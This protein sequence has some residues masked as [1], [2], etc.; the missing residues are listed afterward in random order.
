MIAVIKKII[1]GDKSLRDFQTAAIFKIRH[2]KGLYLA[3]IPFLGL[4]LGGYIYSTLS[5]KT[6]FAIS[7]V[8]LTGFLL[9]LPIVFYVFILYR[10][11]RCGTVPTS[12]AK[13]TTGVLLFPKK[14]SKCHAPLLPEHKWSQD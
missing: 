2:A 4:F 6:S 12:T 10:C 7:V 8:E 3:V 1:K 13:G 5:T 14:C 9:T 11:P